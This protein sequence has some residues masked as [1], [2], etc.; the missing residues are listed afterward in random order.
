[1]KKIVTIILCLA[2]IT[3][4]TTYSFATNAIQPLW[5]NT[6][7][8]DATLNFTGTE[9]TFTA[10]IFGYDHTTDIHFMA[11]LYYKDSNGEWVEQTT[12]GAL[13]TESTLSLDR[14]FTAIRGVEYK[15]DYSIF[16]YAGL[17]YD[18]INLSITRTCP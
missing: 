12:W 14:T 6:L 18:E 5:D 16:V 15:V 10:S 3:C 9:G 13:S 4:L 11:W 7:S 8:V 2:I 17:D 1:M